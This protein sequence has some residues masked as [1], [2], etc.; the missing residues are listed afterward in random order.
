MQIA[1]FD[2]DGTVIDSSHRKA[3]KADGS[4]DLAHWF[5]N[6]KPSKIALDGLLPLIYEMREIYNSGVRVIIC[7]ARTLQKADYDF[8][9]RNNIPFDYVISRPM[10]DM[11]PDGEL[12]KAKIARLLKNLNMPSE[13][14]EMWDDNLEVIA[15]MS[16]IGVK[17]HNA[18]KLNKKYRHRAFQARL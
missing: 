4:L 1:I 11:T 15:A 13:R 18:E 10:G 9:E 3:T 16:E 17:C 12:K 2:L 6:N 7:T 5:E 14:V 8:F